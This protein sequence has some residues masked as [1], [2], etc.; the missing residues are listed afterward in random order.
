MAKQN[1]KEEDTNKDVISVCRYRNSTSVTE[2][3]VQH[4]ITSRD[5]VHF[6]EVP[7]EPGSEKRMFNYRLSLRKESPNIIGLS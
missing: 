4:V 3:E 7:G 1:T 5:I 6:S 2:Y